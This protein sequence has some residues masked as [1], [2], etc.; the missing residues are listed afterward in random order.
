MYDL[1]GKVRMDLEGLEYQYSW[2]NTLF[3]NVVP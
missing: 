1:R 3:L 2:I